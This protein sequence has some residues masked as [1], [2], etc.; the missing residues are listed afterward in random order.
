M[1]FDKYQLDFSQMAIWFCTNASLIFNKCQQVATW[2]YTNTNFIF[3]K[4][5]I[6]K[7]NISTVPPHEKFYVA[8]ERTFQR[9]SIL[10]GRIVKHI[11]II[12]WK[13][14]QD[15]QSSN[16]AVL[17][18]LNAGCLLHLKFNG[19]TIVK[20]LIQLS[21]LTGFGINDLMKWSAYSAYRTSLEALI[22][23]FKTYFSGTRP[24]LFPWCRLVNDA[25]HGEL[26][27]DL[28]KGYLLLLFFSIKKIDEN[29]NSDIF[30][31]HPFNGEPTI[32]D[33]VKK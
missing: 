17:S 15:S 23:I 28:N 16:K 7:I 11:L 9:G 12:N 2:F 25:Y 19:M 6:Y 29:A 24:S 1:I 8:L 10:S 32:S 33:P 5:Q 20:S 18:I 21:M 22:L 30:N 31:Q 27:S 26:R 3:Y 13:E 14:I 4:C